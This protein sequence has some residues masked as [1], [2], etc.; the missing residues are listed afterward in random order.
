MPDFFVTRKDGYLAP[1]TMEDAAVI[2]K[3]Q[4]GKPIKVTVTTPRNGRRLA[5]YWVLCQRIANAIGA[6]AENVSDLL[7]IESGHCSLIRSKRLGEIRLPRSISFAKMSEQD[8]SSFLSRCVEV[9]SNEWGIARADV[10]A[11]VADLI[12]PEVVQA[13]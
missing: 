4:F 5:L 9:I 8:F 11:A 7:K 2:S 6:E 10:Y 13:R 12:S 1:L 3:L